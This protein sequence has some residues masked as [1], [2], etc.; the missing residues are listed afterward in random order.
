MCNFVKN[1]FR[2]VNSSVISLQNLPLSSKTLLTINFKVTL[3]LVMSQLQVD[4]S[5]WSWEMEM[6]KPQKSALQKLHPDIQLGHGIL[7]EGA[8]SR[9]STS[10]CFVWSK[11]KVS[12][13]WGQV[14]SF[15]LKVFQKPCGCEG[16]AKAR[17]PRLVWSWWQITDIW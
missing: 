4:L 11:Q 2:S 13:A 15:P 8:Q 1:P 5:S 16:W 7:F 14:M 6:L 12:T 10:Y 17:S 9:I 3:P